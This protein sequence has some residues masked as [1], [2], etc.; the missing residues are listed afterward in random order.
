MTIRHWVTKES[1]EFFPKALKNSAGNNR[2]IC[3]KEVGEYILGK[4]LATTRAKHGNSHQ[5]IE[6]SFIGSI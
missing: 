4:S 5:Y 1:D 2:L 6:M 3:T